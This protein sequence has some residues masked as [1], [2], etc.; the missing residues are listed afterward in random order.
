MK[1]ASGQELNVKDLFPTNGKFVNTT[2][3]TVSSPSYLEQSV[4]ISFW[5]CYALP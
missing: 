3:L 5:K 4:G 2:Y 1:K